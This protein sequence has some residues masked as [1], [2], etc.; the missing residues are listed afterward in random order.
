MDVSIRN[1]SYGNTA[2]QRRYSQSAAGGGF[3]EETLKARASGGELDGIYDRLSPASQK[4]LEDLKTGRS[5]MT[6]G[7]WNGLCRELK[8]MGVINEAEFNYTRA[9]FHLHPLVSDGRGGVTCPGIKEEFLTRT[10]T[11]SVV[12]SSSD[13]WTG[14]PLEYL[15]EWMKNLQRW[16]GQLSAERWPD[17]ERKYKDLSAYDRQISACQKV[18]E[19]LQGLMNR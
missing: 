8:N 4:T 12:Y 9:D 15:D 3:L 7:Q 2:F 6:K 19:V 18:A 16:K 11:G 13:D 17:G 10:D 1:Y 5:G 14:D